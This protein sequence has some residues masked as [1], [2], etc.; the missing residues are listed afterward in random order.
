[1]KKTK[2]TLIQHEKAKLVTRKQKGFLLD[3][4]YPDL[5]LRNSFLLLA[6]FSNT[7]K[8]TLALMMIINAVRQS[9]FDPCLKLKKV[10]TFVAT[11]EVSDWHIY[12]KLAGIIQG[13]KLPFLATMCNLRGDRRLVDGFFEEHGFEFCIKKVYSLTKEEV[14]TLETGCDIHH[15]VI[16][17]VSSLIGNLE[18]S[19]GSHMSQGL[20]TLRIVEHLS[21]TRK[22][23]K[24]LVACLIRPL[25]MTTEPNE[26]LTPPPPRVVGFPTKAHFLSSMELQAQTYKDGVWLTAV[27]N[28]E[29]PTYARYKIFD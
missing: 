17:D 23:V 11:N 25:A 8:T 21:R 14:E 4:R 18:D 16:D 24:I 3:D 7:F 29:G 19:E 15:L 1:M 5:L 26:V 13:K 10:V 20:N 6:G 28:K 22:G 12:N 2:L 27:R 9:V